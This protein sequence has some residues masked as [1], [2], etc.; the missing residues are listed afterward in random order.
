M[1]GLLARQEDLNI[2]VRIDQRCLMAVRTR[3]VNSQTVVSDSLEC[4]WYAS[5]Q[6]IVRRAMYWYL[7]AMY[8]IGRFYDLDTRQANVNGV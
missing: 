4:S 7:L 5:K 2:I 6:R 3:R 1:P 8:Y